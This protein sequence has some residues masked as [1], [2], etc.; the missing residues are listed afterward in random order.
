[1]IVREPKLMRISSAFTLLGLSLVTLAG[2]NLSDETRAAI[3]TASGFAFAISILLLVA[4]RGELRA[5]TEAR[6]GRGRR[7]AVLAAASVTSW[8]ALG[9]AAA[10]GMWAIAVAA[11]AAA[12]LVTVAVW[13]LIRPTQPE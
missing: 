8:G 13:R 2:V 4:A 9:V 6:P 5:R 1:M 7:I 11:L 3:L 12:A 10:K